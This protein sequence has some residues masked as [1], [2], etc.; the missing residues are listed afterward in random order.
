MYWAKL[1]ISLTLCL[2]VA[3]LGG[4]LSEHPGPMW[5]PPLVKPAWEV[6]DYY[7]TLVWIFLYIMLGISFWLVW[8]TPSPI[9]KDRAYSSFFAMLFVNAII[10]ALWSK[11]FFYMESPFINLVNLSLLLVISIV[12]FSLF[13]KHSKPA[14]ILMIPYILWIVYAGCENISLWMASS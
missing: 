3:W 5:F 8:V 1:V 10:N 4:L 9:E 6:K 13:R 11:L 7:L 12:A 2:G 14:S